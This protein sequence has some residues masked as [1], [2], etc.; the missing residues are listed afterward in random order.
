MSKEK[1]C[2]NCGQPVDEKAVICVSC[3]KKIQKPI[4]KKWWFWVIITV[5]VI[6]I[7]AS[8]GNDEENTASNQVEVTQ[9][10]EVQKQDEPIEYTV[11]TVSELVDVLEE[12][13]LKA[14]KNYK[15]KY[16]EVTGRI[17]VIDSDGKYISLNPTENEFCLTGVQC[18]I[19]NDEQKAI[20]VELS[21]GD[22]ITVKGKI[23]SIGEIMG[24]SLDIDSIN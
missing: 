10:A 5:I 21:R 2:K 7:G 19:K 13:A 11:C 23:K 3:G 9:Q 20:V 4:Y 15:D 6:A 17:S 24:Y 14:E 18:Y 12:N 16:V 22:I 8:G 1:I